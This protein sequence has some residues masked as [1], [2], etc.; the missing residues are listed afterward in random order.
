[1]YSNVAPLYVLYEANVTDSHGD[2]A[3]GNAEMVSVSSVAKAMHL[4]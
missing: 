1:M 4:C 3:G 2:H